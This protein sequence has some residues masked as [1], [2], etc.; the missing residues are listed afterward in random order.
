MRLISDK[1][2]ELLRGAID[3]LGIL[4]AK[5]AQEHCYSTDGYQTAA[6]AGAL[7]Q[8]I[9]DHVSH[10]LWVLHTMFYDSQMRGVEYDTYLT[11]PATYDYEQDRWF[12]G[13]VDATDLIDHVRR[14]YDK[15]REVERQYQETITEA[16]DNYEWIKEAVDEA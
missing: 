15:D 8:L 1:E 4:R 3:K 14:H 12:I 2:E 7:R 6:A 9:N 5:A 10:M 13:D 11:L 16:R